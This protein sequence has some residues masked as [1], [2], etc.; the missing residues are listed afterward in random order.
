MFNMVVCFFQKINPFSVAQFVPFMVLHLVETILLDYQLFKRVWSRWPE[1]RSV[2][3]AFRS[4]KNLGNISIWRKCILP[5]LNDVRYICSVAP[6]RC[7]KGRKVSK[8]F[9]NFF[10]HLWHQ[11]IGGSLCKLNFRWEFFM[12][13]RL[14]HMLAIWFRLSHFSFVIK[15]ECICFHK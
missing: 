4:R 14:A 2:I 10:W 6:W 7:S 12:R 9:L 5:W 8:D 13:R 3:I 15:L 11:L 1:F